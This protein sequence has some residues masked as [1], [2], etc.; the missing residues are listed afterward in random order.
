MI[1][2]KFWQHA[3]S[4]KSFSVRVFRQRY[5]QQ[6]LDQQLQLHAGSCPI[7]SAEDG[8]PFE[9]TEYLL[10]QQQQQQHLQARQM[11]DTGSTKHYVIPDY[12]HRDLGDAMTFD[13][14]RTPVDCGVYDVDYSSRDRK[15]VQTSQKAQNA[16]IMYHLYE[17]PQLTWFVDYIV[18]VLKCWLVYIIS[19]NYEFREF[20]FVCIIRNCLLV[21]CVFSQYIYLDNSPFP[22]INSSSSPN[23]PSSS[24]EL[25]PPP[26]N[27]LSLST[28]ICSFPSHD[29]DPLLHAK[30]ANPSHDL[31]P[32]P[33]NL[34]RE[35]QS[36]TSRL[37]KRVR[38]SSSEWKQSFKF[39][40]SFHCEE[41]I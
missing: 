17:S 29:L 25:D 26:M 33:M 1:I 14:G 28:W 2:I 34:H 20:Y 35:F 8:K 21:R 38:W 39:C 18:R 41:D 19:C 6:S 11:T 9:A 4:L 40:R 7:A 31:A 12:I 3:I 13:G 30:D 36:N 10:Q 22:W 15:H 16:R 37:T 27:W 23:W 24:H 32:L 5:N